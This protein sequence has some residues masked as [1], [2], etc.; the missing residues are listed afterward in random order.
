MKIFAIMYFSKLVLS[1][2]GQIGLSVC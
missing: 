2:Y 1:V